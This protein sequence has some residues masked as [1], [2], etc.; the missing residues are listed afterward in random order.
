MLMLDHT[1]GC[2]CVVYEQSSSGGTTTT[3]EM[4]D[5]QHMNGKPDLRIGAF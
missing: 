2:R 3:L 1:L 5:P 4:V